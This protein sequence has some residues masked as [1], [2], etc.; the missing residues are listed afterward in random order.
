[1]VGGGE[2]SSSS[3]TTNEDRRP[4]KRPITL[5]PSPAAGSI[6]ALVSERKYRHW[7]LKWGGGWG[8]CNNEE[9][10]MKHNS[11]LLVN[12]KRST[13]A[14]TVAVGFRLTFEKIPTSV[15]PITISIGSMKNSHL[16]SAPAPRSFSIS[17]PRRSRVGRPGWEQTAAPVE[18]D[19]TTSRH[20]IQSKLHQTNGGTIHQH[21]P[22]SL[23]RRENDETIARRTASRGI[24]LS[25]DTF[26]ITRWTVRQQQCKKYVHQTPHTL[27]YSPECWE[28]RSWS[29]ARVTTCPWVCPN[30]YG[31]TCRC[32]GGK[33][34]S[35][36]VPDQYVPRCPPHPQKRQNRNNICTRKV[37]T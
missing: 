8:S 34:S 32:S 21:A 7:S 37:T 29:A 6:H 25:P 27:H 3:P 11:L 10:R 5:W 22:N 35:E 9:S 36:S 18:R 31:P 20:P 28:A 4:P 24:E 33:F 12:S 19:E 17:P 26:C 14:F 23:M 15:E 13:A 2:L 30:R 16:S 1:M